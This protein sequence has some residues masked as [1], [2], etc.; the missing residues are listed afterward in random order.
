MLL[1]TRFYI[2]PLRQGAVERPSLIERL[3]ASSGGSLVVLAAPAGYGKTTL[4]SQWLHRHPQ[5]FAWLTLGAEHNATITFW[6]YTIVALRQIQPDIGEVAEAMIRRQ[7]EPDV[8]AVIVALLNDLDRLSIRNSARDPIT[9]V[10]DDFHVLRNVRLLRHISLFLDH[11]PSCIRVVITSRDAPEL[12]LARR[13][14]NGQLLEFGVAELRFDTAES[15]AFLCGT[16]E[17][18]L[19]PQ[20][21]KAFCERT[22]G[23]VAGLQLAAI[24]H[25]RLPDDATGTE[26]DRYVAD[27]LLEEVFG[28]LDQDVQRFLL[29]T[30]SVKRFCAG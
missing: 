4:V 22:E 6:Q 7:G 2:P 29:Q 1:R 8:R 23:W 26:L 9:L 30:A 13:R 5:T 25:H 12:G 10:M 24:S 18:S 21:V 20:Q 3:Q 27:Y 16:M 15:A 17:L 14:A 28:G 19:V 11:L